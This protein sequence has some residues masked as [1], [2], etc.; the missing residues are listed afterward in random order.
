[1]KKYLSK[2]LGFLV[3]G[4]LFLGATAVS[5][6]PNW[7]VA[8]SY[9]IVINYLGSDYT[10]NVSFTQDIVGDLDGT[11]TSG[12]YAWDMISGSV[13]GDDIEFEADYTATPDAVSPQT[14]MN[15]IGT[16]ALDGS[17]SGTWD[18]NYNGGSRNGTW[19]AV[20]GTAD[21]ILPQTIAFDPVASQTYGDPDFTVSA[22]GGA[23]GN[24][25]IFSTSS[26]AC[27]I[28]STT[29]TSAT[30]AIE[31]AGMTP[32]SMVQDMQQSFGQY[33]LVPATTTSC[34]GGTMPMSQALAQSRN[35][36]SAYIMKQLDNTGNNGGM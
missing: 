1:M 23:S 17:M 18:D 3:L 8:G 7:N 25:V 22:T 19:T 9:D 36:A 24:D 5:A 27:A 13:D 6:A 35:C 20:A 30:L 14:T 21:P 12:A 31:E 2:G 16:I 11:G 32:S 28:V 26:S 10:H 15:I 34:T 29:S 4:S 33:G